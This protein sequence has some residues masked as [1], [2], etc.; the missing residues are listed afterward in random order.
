MLSNLPGWAR[1]IVALLII[2]IVVILVALVVHALGGF[3]WHMRI[4]FFRFLIGV[5]G[6]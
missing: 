4:G 3:D 5:T 6:H 1:A 2:I